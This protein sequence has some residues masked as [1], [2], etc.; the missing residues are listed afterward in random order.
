MSKA[1]SR[2]GYVGKTLK[3]ADKVIVKEELDRACL[4]K[5]LHDLK[6]LCVNKERSNDSAGKENEQNNVLIAYELYDLDVGNEK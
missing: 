1:V 3:C 5:A 4:E 2:P 6:N